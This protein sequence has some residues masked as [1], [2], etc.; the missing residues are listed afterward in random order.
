M[1][2]MDEIIELVPAL[3]A[4]LA[5]GPHLLATAHQQGEVS[6]V[7]DFVSVRLIPGGASHFI[8][9]CVRRCSEGSANLL[10]VTAGCVGIQCVQKTCNLSCCC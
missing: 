8:V 10:D 3:Q 5:S 9:C 6:A 7:D 2:Q 4:C 1:S